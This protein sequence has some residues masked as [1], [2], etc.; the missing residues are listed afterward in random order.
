MTSCCPEVK[1]RLPGL[2]S[3]YLMSHMLYSESRISP[4]ALNWVAH[5]LASLLGVSHLVVKAACLSVSACC[6]YLWHFSA[7]VTNE[8]ME[9]LLAPTQ[10]SL[11]LLFSSSFLCHLLHEVFPDPFSGSLLS[12]FE[13][14]WP[15]FITPVLCHFIPFYSLPTA[16]HSTLISPGAYWI[17]GSLNAIFLILWNVKLLGYELL[18]KPFKK[19]FKWN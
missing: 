7:Q 1:L 11:S 13:L 18:P 14:H 10:E 16:S 15:C 4:T 5:N 6:L 8:W 17:D 9:R 12:S 2:A 3:R 19:E